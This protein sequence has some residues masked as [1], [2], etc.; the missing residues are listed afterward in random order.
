MREN[1]TLLDGYI[2]F[3]IPEESRDDKK[4]HG[5]LKTAAETLNRC[6]ESLNISQ[7]SM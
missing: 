5:D 1:H 4:M 3:G 2:T 7:E 6:I